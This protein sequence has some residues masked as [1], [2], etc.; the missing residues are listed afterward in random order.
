MLTAAFPRTG[1]DGLVWIALLPLLAAIRDQKPGAAFRLGFIAGMAH[2]ATLVY[3]VVHTMR[4]YGHLPLYLAIPALLLLASY[5]ALYPAMFSAILVRICPGPAAAWVLIPFLWTGTEYLR[6]TLFT[7]F[8]WELLGYS[9]FQRLWLIQIADLSGPYGLS[10]LIALANGTA[11]LTLFYQKGLMWQDSLVKKT[12]VLVAPSVFAACLAAALIYG[13]LRIQA[14]DQE[15]ADAKTLRVAAIQ[16]NIPQEIKWDRAHRKTTIESYLSLTQ[17][18][19]QKGAQ[20]A[21]WPETATPFHFFHH[22]TYT[23]MV[24]DGVRKSGIPLLT[25]SPYVEQDQGDYRFFN[26]AFLLLPDG[27]AAGRYDKVHL[28]PYGEYVPLQKWMPFIKKLVQQV[29]D[30]NTG[31]M[32]Q[33]LEADGFDLGVL[34]CYE[35]I[36]PELSRSAANS[37]AAIL[38]NLTNDAWYGRTSAPY[39]HFS[40]AVF[41]A[42]E[43][44]RALVR[45]ANTGI[46]GFI[47]PVGRNSGTTSLF[48][49][50]TTIQELPLMDGRTLYM[51]WGDAF[52]LGC[53]IVSAIFCV[54]NIVN[55]SEV[56]LKP[57]RS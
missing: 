20:L 23:S 8:P 44:R 40:M 30:F 9:Q 11:M 27:T 3:W 42:V 50:T 22:K 49:K 36:F 29:G 28:V 57:R 17:K 53:L 1:L 16:G 21:V 32:G 56:F 31:K 26:S 41:R 55:I 45:A 38:A 24:T 19:A 33:V 10:F 51:K 46:S 48:E 39:Q 14:V 25:G 18:A 47:D 35:I 52:P 7:G 2:Y 37:G 15:V 5:M 4:T 12:W 13:A 54:W 6:A 34:I 43:N